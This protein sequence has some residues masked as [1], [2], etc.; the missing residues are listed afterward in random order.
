MQ[1][2]TI[3]TS[4]YARN[5]ENPD[6]I[7]I[8]ASIP[9]YYKGKWMPELGPEWKTLDKLANGEYPSNNEYVADYLRDVTNRG[10][11]PEKIWEM[12]PDGAILLCYE[13]PEDFCHRRVL[14]EWLEM[15]L[16]VK[17]PEWETT[18]ERQ[19]RESKERHQTL[20]DSVLEF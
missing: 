16:Q 6:S 10:L 8:S 9:H 14:A 18:E 12:L 11:T 1:D 4:Y 5:T 20:V 3:Y 15:H 17:I 19:T 7:A 2:K 13:K